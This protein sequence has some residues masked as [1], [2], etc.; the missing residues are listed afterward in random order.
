MTSGCGTR[1]N[2]LIYSQLGIQRLD[3]HQLSDAD[4]AQRP[5][6]TTFRRNSRKS[7]N[8]CRGDRNVDVLGF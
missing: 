7:E 3:P 4:A 5:I 2:E 8:V 1:R 6:F